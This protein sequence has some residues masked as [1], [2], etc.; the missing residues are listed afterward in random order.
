VDTYRAVEMIPEDVILY[1]HKQFERYKQKKQFK[2]SQRLNKHENFNNNSHKNSS[3]HN[4]ENSK[5]NDN[6]DTDTNIRHIIEMDKMENDLF[7]AKYRVNNTM[8]LIDEGFTENTCR[9]LANQKITTS[10]IV[11]TDDLTIPPPLTK[12]MM[13]I[14]FENVDLCV[15]GILEKWVETKEIIQE[16]FPWL[17]INKIKDE[18]KLMHLFSNKET[19]D[20][21]RGDL[22]QMLI[23]KNPCDMKIYNK[24]ITRFHVQMNILQNRKNTHFVPFF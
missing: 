10:K 22:K 16:W 2:Q 8:L 17:E 6:I 13:K 4:H 20:N 23:N 14:A 7:Y 21:L 9:M 19:R 24:M 18:I 3:D 15:I 1:K 12:N 5:N 11:G